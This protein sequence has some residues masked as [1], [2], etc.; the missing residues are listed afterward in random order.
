MDLR[1]CGEEWAGGSG[2][3]LECSV[4]MGIVKGVDYVMDSS[5]EVGRG[6]SP[7]M[8][9]AVCRMVLVIDLC[10]LSGS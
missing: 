6:V 9:V 4:L 5:L 1:G 7:R 2:E 10:Y 8:P 3:R